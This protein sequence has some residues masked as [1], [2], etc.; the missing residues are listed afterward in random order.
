[1]T[2]T[3]PVPMIAASPARRSLRIRRWINASIVGALAV[4]TVSIDRSGLTLVPVLFLLVVPFEKLVPRHRQRLRRPGLGTDIVYALTQ[5]L[6]GVISITAVFAVGLLSLAWVPGLLVR[7]LVMLLPAPVRTVVGLALFDLIIY[8]AHRLSHDVAFLWRFHR[9][10]HS[11]ERM[12]WLSGIRSHPFDGAL[13]APP[14]AFLIGAGFSPEFTGVLAI[15]QIVTGL[16]LH[17]N[18]RWRW[19][20]LHR[21]V[22]TPEFHHWHHADE[23]PAHSTNHAVF[24]PVW[25]IIFGTYYMPP[26]RRPLRYGLTD[27]LRPVPSSFLAQLRDPFLGLR[28][29]SLRHPVRELSTTATTLRRG[30]GQVAAVRHRRRSP[31]RFETMTGSRRHRWWPP[32]PRWV[33][34]AVVGALVAFDLVAAGYVRTGG[35]AQSAS[36]SVGV[37]FLIVLGDC[38]L[39]FRRSRP[40]LTVALMLAA[41]IVASAAADPGLFTQHIGLHVALVSF[42]VGSWSRHRRWATV[43]PIAGWVVVLIT[44][45]DDETDIVQVATIG[46]VLIAL[47]W[48]AGLAARSRRLYLEQVEQ[49]L[50][51]VERER[52]E[53]ARRAVLDER[54]HIA[55]EL[56][57]V[58]AHHVSLIGVQAGAARMALDSQLEA[59]PGVVRDAL[60]A[61]EASSRDAVGEMRQLLGTLRDETPLPDGAMGS[62]EPQPG[63]SLLPTLLAGF[64]QTGLAISLDLRGDPIEELPPLLSACCYRLLEESLTN[65]VRHSGAS[66]VW[67]VFEAN[68]TS[69][70]IA[71]H[72]PGPT[73]VDRPGSRRGLVGMAERIALLDG[74]LS[75]GPTGDGGFTVMAE[76]PR[77]D[78]P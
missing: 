22:I 71:V 49:R 48:M 8:W 56:H 45:V 61:I 72:D 18:V 65:V 73:R 47:P 32:G 77:L 3:E 25:D 67:V 35:E 68:A 15:V 1:M 24:L 19:R 38:A 14:V 20:W 26:D 37:A 11:S 39:W 5:P 21:I 76:L 78:T 62:L 28:V 41:T 6:L 54:N 50:E 17:A 30:L 34:P 57:D 33:D 69:V 60:R 46:L 40:L 23:P 29:P 31:L 58:V 16:F 53:Q 13:L 43:L 52:D 63:L 66:W 10:H 70:R 36:L 64:R 4:G 75:H 74:H 44:A 55:R 51:S 27:P 59:V 42:A 7:P 12:D 2:V 9:V